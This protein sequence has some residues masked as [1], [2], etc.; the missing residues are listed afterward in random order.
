MSDVQAILQEAFALG[1]DE[2]WLEMAQLLGEALQ[3][4]PDE[5]YLLCWAG[6]AERELGNDGAAYEMFK[7]CVAQN[8]LD[9]HLLALAGSGLA[10]FGDPDA[11]IALRA[12]ALSQPDLATARVQYG[13]FLARAGLFEEALEHL[14]AGLALTPEDPFAHG[15]M[16]VAL[17]LKGDLAGAVEAMENALDLAPE[18]S[19]TRVLL[20]LLQLELDRPEDAAHT[21]ADAA[22]ERVDDAEAQIL[23]ALACA[24]VGWVDTAEEALARAEY[25]AEGG[26]A[27]LLSEAGDRVAS[28]A[29]DARSLLMDQVAPSALHDRLT[30]PL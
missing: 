22:R 11:E 24:A 26:D 6:V 12:A 1:D 3:D 2:R 9:A 29:D 25:A 28:G 10:A 17:A 27:E 15:E 4:D 7:R 20:G 8:P 18:D 19:W 13:A 16:G 30:Q 5:P 21:L 23:A 14:T